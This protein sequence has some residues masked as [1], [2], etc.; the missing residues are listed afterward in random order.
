MVGVLFIEIGKIRKDRF[1][2]GVEDVCFFFRFEFEI[3][4]S[5][6]NNMGVVM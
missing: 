5:R 1:G 3:F 2:G 4:F 6:V